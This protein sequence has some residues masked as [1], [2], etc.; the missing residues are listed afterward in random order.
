MKTTK[1]RIHRIHL[2]GS[3]LVVFCIILLSI[4]TSCEGEETI[5]EPIVDNT[6]SNTRGVSEM[7]LAN[8]YYGKSSSTDCNFEYEGL[9]GPEFWANLCGDEWVDCGGNAQS[10]I[11][12]ITSAV[13]EDGSINNININYGESTTDIINNGHTVQFNYDMG[14]YASLDNIN[15]DLLQFHFHT[16]SEHTVN[17]KRYP[18]EMHLVHQDP[19]TKLLGVVGVFFEEGEEN[20]VLE[21]YL[22]DLPEQ[23]GDHFT[24]T[25]TFKV[26]DLLP[27]DMDFYTYGGS[28]TTPGCS[29]IVT[30]FV[31]KE[32]ITASTE[33]LEKFESIMHKNYRPT[34]DLNG[35]IVKTKS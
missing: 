3:I 1:L 4:L 22:D 18:M 15:Y 30:W 16:G 14:S 35:R 25:S 13:T 23:K 19:I 31:V 33:Q 8:I 9:E 20:D 17:G 11:N 27:G 28:L 32:S 29:E 7:E 26:E 24:N 2:K 10:P 5:Q 6:N 12:I 34:Q 21:E